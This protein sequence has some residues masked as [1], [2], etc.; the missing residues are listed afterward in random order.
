MEAYSAGSLDDLMLKPAFQSNQRVKFKAL[1]Q[2][3]IAVDGMHQLRCA[4]GDL[5]PANLLVDYDQREP[6]RIAVGLSDFGMATDFSNIIQA[7]GEAK[8]GTGTPGFQAPEVTKDTAF[9]ADT[10]L[11]KHFE[12]LDRYSFGV[13]VY[14]VLTEKHNEESL[15]VFRQDNWRNYSDEDIEVII[16]PMR[17][18]F[19]P[20]VLNLLKRSLSKVPALRPSIQEWIPVLHRASLIS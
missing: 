5:K 10:D 6:D 9:I 17:N 15:T 4:H 7:R 18:Q 8:T 1:E 13:T 16:G 14:S 12:D 2:L 19:A 11:F 20:E 3:A